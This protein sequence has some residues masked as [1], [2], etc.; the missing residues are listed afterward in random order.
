VDNAGRIAVSPDSLA[1]L[2]R[3]AAA[4]APD[5]AT[6]AAAL[7][8]GS[9]ALAGLASGEALAEVGRLWARQLQ[10]LGDRWRVLARDVAQAGLDYGEVDADLAS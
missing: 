1:E 10:A 5:P 3:T 2:A 6:L 4:R 8:A 7:A 9:E